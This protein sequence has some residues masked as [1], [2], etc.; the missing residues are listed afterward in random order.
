MCVI[1]ERG[2]GAPPAECFFLWCLILWTRVSQPS[3][4]PCPLHGHSL[5]LA[6]HVSFLYCGQP[7]LRVKSCLCAW[8]PCLRKC[9]FFFSD[10][11]CFYIEKALTLI[12]CHSCSSC[13]IKAGKIESRIK[14]MSCNFLTKCFLNITI[15]RWGNYIKNEEKRVLMSSAIDIT[16]QNPTPAF[17]YI[18]FF[19]CA[20]VNICGGK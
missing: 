10:L 4:L 20:Q 13:W 19:P 9:F 8:P 15:V 17:I 12:F 14:C 18:W 7:C 11:E 16:K 2:V 1:L 6:Q 3:P 5:S